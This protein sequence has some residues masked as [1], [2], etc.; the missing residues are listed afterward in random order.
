MSRSTAAARPA[1][2]PAAEH[3]RLG[4]FVGTWDLEG[5]QHA[6]PVGPAAEITGLERFEWL[7]GAFFLVHRFE[8]RVA[9]A[10]TACI[11]VTG[12]DASTG[13]YPTRTY[14]NN[15]QQADWQMTE[16]NGTWFLTGEWPIGG[17]TA[18]VRC[19]IEFADEGN[20]RTARWE[21]SSDGAHWETFWDVK[22]TRA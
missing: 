4:I 10:A 11:E 6:S 2:S 22:A 3:R 13:T 19:T 21:S 16:R 1:P 12:Y 18:Q 7:S 15:G 14:Y 20:T 9:G 5:R 17:E 8:A